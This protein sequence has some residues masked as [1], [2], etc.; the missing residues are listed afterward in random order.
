MNRNK[1]IVATRQSALALTQTRQIVAL[2]EKAN[3]GAR[4]EL[5]AVTS[6]GDRVTDKP[7]RAF[8]GQGVFVKELETA[9]QSGQADLAV[10][11]LKDVPN[12]QP[13]DLILASFPKRANPFDLLLCRKGLT[14]A[15]LP[16]GATVG[17]GSPRRIVQIKAARPDLMFKELRG[18]LDTRIRKLGEG[19]YDA[20]MVAAAGMGRLSIP[21][22]ASQALPRD[23]CLPAIGQ[24]VITLEC[25]KDDED[26]RQIA[27]A[28]NDP[29]TEKEALCERALMREVGAGC[30]A[31]IA[32]F[33][34]TRDGGIT[35]SALIG[36]LTTGQIARET[37]TCAAKDYEECGMLAGRAL[38]TQCKKL[39]I[40]LS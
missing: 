8:G 4:F 15:T 33:A 12:A 11:S 31:P 16:P 19:L 26:A 29:V 22:D 20:I 14:L 39:G 30:S 35:L 37:R 13:E 3:P 27:G 7:L 25:R 10:H 24:G 38:I 34:E 21:F 2:L 1:F 32:A 18:N 5:L 23:L 40:P 6:T 28:I 17:T 36:D 9:L